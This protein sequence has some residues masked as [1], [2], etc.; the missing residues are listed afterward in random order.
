MVDLT[1][2]QLDILNASHT[3]NMLVSGAP[4]TGK[5]VL[6]IYRASD[7]SRER[8]KTL[9]LVY[10]KPLRSYISSAM[11]SL[12]L[13]AEVSTYHSWLWSV[14]K[15]VLRKRQPSNDDYQW[16]LDVVINDFRQLGFIYD[17]I[18]IDEAQDFPLKLV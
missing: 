15:N 16:D 5:S 10:N 6:A 9:L 4:G 11:R 12:D 14:Y 1:N 18:L 7:L 2:D 13:T 8:K 3:K 17:C